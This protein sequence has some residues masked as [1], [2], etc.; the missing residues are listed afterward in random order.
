MIFVP[1]KYHRRE[2]HIYQKTYIAAITILVL[3]LVIV[4]VLGSCA[5]GLR[6][7]ILEKRQPRKMLSAYSL[8]YNN[9]GASNDGQYSN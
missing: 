1:P 5:A 4:S 2:T 6:A 8:V 9:I 7:L 3:S